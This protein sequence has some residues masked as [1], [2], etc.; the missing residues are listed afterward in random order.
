MPDRSHARHDRHEETPS[1]KSFQRPEMFRRDKTKWAA[2]Q[3]RQINTGTAGEI[4][5]P[6]F[7]HVKVGI[8]S[9]LVP[10]TSQDS[11]F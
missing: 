7:G 11:R 3:S 10:V 6:L 8:A 4:W 2:R 9:N 5:I 1:F